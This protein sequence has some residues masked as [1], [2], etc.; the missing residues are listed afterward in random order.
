MNIL[1]TELMDQIMFAAWMPLMYCFKLLY[2]N[3]LIFLDYRICRDSIIMAEWVRWGH[4]LKG[5]EC[6][7]E[8]F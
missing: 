7:P 4:I 3:A 8:T 5:F 2:D 6:Q 1:C